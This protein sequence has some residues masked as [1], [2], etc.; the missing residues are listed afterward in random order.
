MSRG[1]NV[2]VA[3]AAALLRALA[4]AA[5][6]LL[7]GPD[8]AAP[9]TPGFC[10]A[11]ATRR[12]AA[13]APVPADQVVGWKASQKARAVESAHPQRE[14]FAVAPAARSIVYFF[15]PVDLSSTEPIALDLT[16]RLEGWD[17]I[18]YIA[19]GW[20]DGRR[21]WHV[22]VKHV[23]DG[24]TYSTSIDPSSV[25]FLIANDWAV[26]ES[27]TVD[28]ARVVVDGTPGPA[29][30]VELA[31][32]RFRAAGTFPHYPI[33]TAG[34]T[35]TRESLR[36]WIDDPK[37]RGVSRF[38]ELWTDLGFYDARD[39]VE[40]ARALEERNEYRL[41]N[42]QPFVAERIG[43]ETPAA[44]GESITRRFRWHTLNIAAD[45]VAAHAQTKDP[46]FLELAKSHVRGWLANDFRRPS[47]DPKYAW[48]DHGT[49]ERLIAL[50]FLWEESAATGRDPAFSEDLFYAIF[51]HAELLADPS[52]YVKNQPLI[53]HNHAVF[54]DVAL[55]GATI[56]VPEVAD[57]ADW[58]ATGIERLLRQFD[59]LVA[60]DGASI[61]NSWSYHQGLQELC[62][63]SS[64]LLKSVSPGDEAERRLGATCEAMRDFS[65]R[66]RYP[67]ETAPAFG[68]SLFASNERRLSK[69]RSSTV[70]EDELWF[71]ESGYAALR[72]RPRPGLPGWQ[73][74]VFDS[75]L[76]IT[77]KHAD[78]LSFTL[79]ADGLEWL[80]DPG[81]FV[82]PSNP[83]WAR[84]RN[85]SAHNTFLA[86]GA[87]PDIG[88]GVT[89]LSPRPAGEPANGL[90]EIGGAHRG[91]PEREAGRTFR[92]DREAGRIVLDDR[93]ERPCPQERPSELW[94]QAGDGVVMS[95]GADG[96]IV[97]EHGAS[98]TRISI[99][100]PSDAECDLFRG[101]TEPFLAGWLYPD[102]EEAAPA[103]AARC[104]IEP[105]RA[106]WS[107]EIELR[108]PERP[109]P[110]S[111]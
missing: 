25:A 58:Q 47:D 104:R 29:A 81:Y 70:T 98:E 55:L 52:F 90:V 50:L 63:A 5:L 1:S 21:Y 64:R 31:T 6:L 68:D 23:V 103:H 92:I 109:R 77:H 101:R 53:L 73:M 66:M 74:N 89:E 22:P 37:S 76:S 85:A 69:G 44:V 24:V 108:R 43:T 88:V 34:C 39:I 97:L 65:L 83:H 41:K 40:T 99:R 102:F 67:D 11:A 45:L 48:Y 36:R 78:F 35:V 17:E 19:L 10:D 28:T 84:A 13:A 20:Q 51:K 49:A 107:T 91:Y 56:S 33:R 32:P 46:T 111:R 72:S 30:T 95:P 82:P 27:W 8:A 105:D 16:F 54:Q 14:R 96:E 93:L 2:G 100:P 94:F 62:L 57:I 80:V 86:C 3:P 110:Q 15:D 60:P 12:T 79:W 87:E 71:F 61:E 42:L 9:A 38:R 26:P 106:S 7:A 59:G 18:R 4:G 75:S